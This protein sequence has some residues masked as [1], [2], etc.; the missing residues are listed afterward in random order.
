MTESTVESRSTEVI[1]CETFA[2]ETFTPEDVGGQPVTLN[3]NVAVLFLAQILG[4]SVLSSTVLIAPLIGVDLSHTRHLATLPVALTIVGTALGVVPVT[5]LM[6]RFGR[7]AV[8][9]LVST[10][11]LAGCLLAL[12]ALH[13]RDFRLF[14]GACM[15]L[16]VF[17]AGVMQFRFAAMESVAPEQMASAASTIIFGGIVAAWLGPELAFTGQHLLR[18]EYAGSYLLLAGTLILCGALLTGFRN[19]PPATGVPVEPPRPFFELLK[20]PALWLAI[21]AGSVGYAVMSGVMTPTSVSMHLLHGHSDADAKWVI[22]SHIA[23]MFLPSLFAPRLI[24]RL[25]IRGLIAVGMVAMFA[26]LVAGLR[27]TGVPGYWTTLILVGIGWNF[28]FTGGTT[29]L[30]QLPR[31][32]EQFRVQALNEG[33]IFPVQA[34]ASFASGWLLAL[35]GWSGVLYAG[36]PL[37]G[38]LLLV[39]LFERGSSLYRARE[40]S[41]IQG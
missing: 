40:T 12:Q 11:A 2:S 36:M 8:F 31:D 13:I 33:I 37:L 41:R 28:L 4:F 32:G 21:G 9:L 7:R 16:G 35:W 17:A 30:G 5:L 24:R 26:A 19:R 38:T 39:L 29:L 23:A 6:R 15:M 18:V 20:I 10:I 25:G 22:Q 1:A 34:L 3:R 27:N 14:C